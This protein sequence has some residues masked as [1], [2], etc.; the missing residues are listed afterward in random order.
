[1]PPFCA[2]GRSV[3]QRGNVKTEFFPPGIVR[4]QY[5]FLVQVGHYRNN[6]V[7]RKIVLQIYAGNRDFCKRLLFYFE[8]PKAIIA[9]LLWV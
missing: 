6:R 2:A 3:V 4:I 8:A 5:G 9:N 1:M 7:G